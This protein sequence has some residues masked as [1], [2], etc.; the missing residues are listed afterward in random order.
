MLGKVCDRRCRRLSSKKLS[1]PNGNQAFSTTSTQWD[2][3]ASFTYVL[4]G[5]LWEKREG[6]IR[7]ET[8]YGT[9]HSSS[10]G[11]GSAI[12]LPF[13]CES[14]SE[15]D[16]ASVHLTRMDACGGCRG[17]LRELSGA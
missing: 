3:F 6:R 1:R 16:V 5:R 17:H 13:A 10:K 7:M 2:G 14:E 4:S 11:Y 12:H 9:T 8:G 15:R